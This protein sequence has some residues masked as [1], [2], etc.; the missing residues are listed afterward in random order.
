MVA[1]VHMTMVTQA[2]AAARVSGA[3]ATA[4]LDGSG[5]IH[6]VPNLILAM[7][8]DGCGDGDAYSIL[9]EDRAGA[10]SFICAHTWRWYGAKATSAWCC[11]R[12]D[13]MGTEANGGDLS[14]EVSRSSRLSSIL[15]GQREGVDL[16]G[17]VRRG[18]GARHTSS[19]GEV[20]APWSPTA[21]T[22]ASNNELDP[23][24]WCDMEAIPYQVGMVRS[25]R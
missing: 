20:L 6:P 4:R 8:D 13:G 9:T 17:N 14:V 10:P 11:R 22:E 18:G 15:A 1:S 5:S 23:G 19:D 21:H 7:D 24:R 12:G 16:A 25:I 2:S 3:T